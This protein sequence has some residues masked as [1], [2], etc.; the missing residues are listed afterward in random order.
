M[1][2]IFPAIDLIDGKTVRLREGRFSDKTVYGSE[3]VEIAKKYAK[4]GYRNLHLVD[5]DGAR[6]GRIRHLEILREITENT[7]LHVDF[8]GGVRTDDD[9]HKILNAG[10]R[11]VN[12]GSIAVREPLLLKQW[13]T[14][15][16]I[17]RFIASVDLRNEVPAVYGW[18]QE[19]D[20]SW[21]TVIQNLEDLG[22]TFFSVTAIRRDGKMKGADIELYRKIRAAFPEISLI[23]SGG[24]SSVDEI[25]ILDAMGM[26]GVIV[27]KAL[28]DGK[29][30]INELKEYL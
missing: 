5:L 26:Y 16:G 23:A 2:E 13:I 8:G 28:L 29:M 19:S 27:G 11:Q 9:V 22:I 24:V 12:V 25:R 20:I 6:T 14:T 21:Q 17:D 7:G 10:A 30:D 4:S 3:P 18:Q 1:I 15:F